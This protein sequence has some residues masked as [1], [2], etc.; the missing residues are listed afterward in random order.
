MDFHATITILRAADGGALG[1]VDGSGGA[2]GSRRPRGS[3]DGTE[4][5]CRMHGDSDGGAKAASGLHCNSGGEAMHGLH[6]DDT[7]ATSELRGDGSEEATHGLRG[8]NTEAPMGCVVTTSMKPHMG[9]LPAAR[10]LTLLHGDSS[11][12]VVN[13]LCG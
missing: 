6:G 1:D 3:V 8:G 4:A 11:E 9:Y 7:E 10:R 5:E 2:C 13:W 12:D